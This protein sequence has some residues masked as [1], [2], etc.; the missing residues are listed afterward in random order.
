MNYTAYTVYLESRSH[1]NGQ[2]KMTEEWMTK[3]SRYVEW[4]TIVLHRYMV[5]Q[6][7]QLESQKGGPSTQA[8]LIHCSV[9]IKIG[10]RR[11]LSRKMDKIV[12][13][14]IIAKVCHFRIRIP[15]VVLFL[16]P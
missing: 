13:I 1:T 12:R 7:L 15:S 11:G 2:H 3:E 4:T 6:C 10:Y 8:G 14:K 9:Q 16:P 5:C